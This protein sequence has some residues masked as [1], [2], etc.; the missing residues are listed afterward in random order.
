MKNILLTLTAIAGVTFVS[1]AQEITGFQKG[2]FI[3]EGS[4][5]YNHADNENTQIK[6]SAFGFS[7]KVGAFLSERVALGVDLSIGSTSRENYSGSTT[8]KLN[9]NSFGFGAFG[10]YYFLELGNRFKTYTELGVGYN[11]SIVK[12]ITGGNTTDS[13]SVNGIGVNAGLGANYFLTD[14]LAINFSFA[15]LIGYNSKRVDWNGDKATN[16]FDVNINNF[17]NFF[18]AAQFGLTFKL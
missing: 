9:T 7:P 17:N 6:T 5:T 12:T 2:N 15:N 14:K 1:N 10:R 16:N 18:N 4:L 13:P 3:V 8:V 11:S